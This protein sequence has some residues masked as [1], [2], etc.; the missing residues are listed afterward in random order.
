MGQAK[1]RG[2]LEQRVQE[3]K[4]RIDALR[5]EVI[6]CNDCKGEIRD[7]IDLPAKGLD[8]ID[9]VFGGICP[10]CKSTTYAVKGDPQAVERL[11][12]AMAEATGDDPLVG[13]Q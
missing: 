9:A 11:M 13:V 10:E 1:R 6:V 7:I 3:A 4:A 12:V 5:P 2:T 8:G